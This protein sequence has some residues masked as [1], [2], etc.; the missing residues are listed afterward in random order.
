MRDSE[1]PITLTIAN[2]YSLSRAA[3][4]GMLAAQ[5]GFEVVAEVSCPV[6]INR[7]ARGVNQDILLT[8]LCFQGV[9]PFEEISRASAHTRVVV[10]SRHEETD[11]VREAVR[12]GAHAYLPQTSSLDELFA[13]LRAVADGVPYMHHSIGGKLA[14]GSCDPTTERERAVIRLLASGH[15]TEEAGSILHVSTRTIEGDRAALR[16]K[17]GLQTRA[18]LFCYARDH[19][20]LLGCPGER[21]PGR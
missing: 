10:I 7:T 3:W 12:S 11:L 20:Y 9:H 19:G 1:S 17:L 13:A 14:G 4:H 15:T 6:N 5:A 18:E 16:E 8:D 2:H 21:T